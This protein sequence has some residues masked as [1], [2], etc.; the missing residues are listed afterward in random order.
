VARQ[1]LVLEEIV[2]ILQAVGIPD[3]P[4]DKFKEHAARIIGSKNEQGTDAL[5]ISS[6][7]GQKSQVGFVDLTVNDTR[8]QMPIE[9]AREVG[10]MLLNA[11]E[12][13]ASDQMFVTLL[14]KS[15]L[16]NPETV[17][18]VLLELREI[19]QGTKGISWPS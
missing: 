7:F 19:R 4:I 8:I 18:G 9:K 1:V 12:A 14:Q 11:A 15:G 17:G 10:I 6:G 16:D 3:G 5:T 13:A 2:A